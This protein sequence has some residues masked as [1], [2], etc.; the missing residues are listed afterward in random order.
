MADAANRLHFYVID[1]RRDDKG[2]LSYTVGVRSL[3][4]AGPQ[5]RGVSGVGA[6]ALAVA[7]SS[8]FNVT[9]RNTGAAAPARTRRR[10][11]GC[12]AVPSTA[13]S[14]VCRSRSTVPVVRRLQTRSSR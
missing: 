8:T 1:V 3:D 12:R 13:T 4:G 11:H 2:M 9:L 10:I 6:S 5:A 14:I 7:G